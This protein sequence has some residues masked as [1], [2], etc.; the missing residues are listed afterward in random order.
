MPGWL[1]CTYA[2]L[3]SV[4]RF[5]LSELRFDEQTIDGIP[6][7]QIVAAVVIGIAI[8][9]AGV[10]RR[11]PRQGHRGV[12]GDRV[13]G[14]PLEAEPEDESTP[15]PAMSASVPVTLYTRAGCH[16]CDEAR[17]LLDTLAGSLGF[18]LEAVDIDQDAELRDRYHEAVPVIALGA[19]EIAR[20]PIR[21]AA[22]EARLRERYR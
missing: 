17:V 13:F 10:L 3:Y 4:M 9:L 15:A 12:G 8:I 1:F 2:V 20:A 7:P 14:P 18:S 11:F 6:V 19:E 21:A 22:L 16:L 5:G